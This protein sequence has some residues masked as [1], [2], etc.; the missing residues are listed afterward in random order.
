MC[1]AWHLLVGKEL[2]L[3]MDVK[4]PAINDVNHIRDFIKKPVVP[5][6]WSL[7][8]LFSAGAAC[9]SVALAR[10]VPFAASFL[11][12]IF[13]KAGMKHWAL[14][15]ALLCSQISKQIAVNK[16]T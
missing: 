10:R 7:R 9:V 12:L 5:L 2:S 14:P 15:I 1:L 6:L 16:S 13:N 11:L 4:T 8:K 3:P